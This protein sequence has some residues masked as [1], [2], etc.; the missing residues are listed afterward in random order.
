[1]LSEMTRHRTQVLMQSYSICGIRLQ[2]RSFQ[3]DLVV[4][5]APLPPPAWLQADS[6][7]SRREHRQ[8]QLLLSCIYYNNL[9]LEVWNCSGLLRKDTKTLVLQK[10]CQYYSFKSVDEN[11]LMSTAIYI[12]FCSESFEQKTLNKISIIIRRDYNHHKLLKCQYCGKESWQY[13]CDNY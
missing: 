5:A 10:E 11:N 4:Q 12:S 13:Q 3:Q 2:L 7:L 1:M 8:T 9:V 6:C